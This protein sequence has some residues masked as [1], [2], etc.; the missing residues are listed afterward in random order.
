M[1]RAFSRRF[2]VLM[3]TPD[4]ELERSVRDAFAE[5]GLDLQVR[6]GPSSINDD[7]VRA[8]PDLVLLDADI[9]GFDVRDVVGVLKIDPRTA[10]V[11]IF[12]MSGVARH[13]GRAFAL[14]IGADEY[15]N[16][17]LAPRSVARGIR[18]H[19][20]TRAKEQPASA[21]MIA[22]LVDTSSVD[23]RDSALLRAQEVERAKTRKSPR[24]RK[25]DRPILIVEDDEDLREVLAQVLEG[26]GMRTL[27]ARNGQ[28]ALDILH[29][30]GVTPG[31]ILLDLT[32]P[33]MNGWEFR[34]RFDTDA[35][36]PDVPVVVMSARSRDDSLSSAAWL[37]KPLRVDVLLNTVQKVALAL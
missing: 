14:E 1:A 35:S 10:S 20:Q 29:S 30:D 2:Q 19:L 27:A 23:C 7:V 33:I 36:I 15:L 34:E 18:S 22:S 25:T 26:E 6:R 32:M 31:L 37:Q 28:E 13:W 24:T 8:N 16:K 5:K 12:L 17:P 11:P 4:E 21:T 9:R 3:V